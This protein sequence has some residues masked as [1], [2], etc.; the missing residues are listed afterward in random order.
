[1]HDLACSRSHH[2]EHLYTSR[3]SHCKQLNSTNAVLWPLRSELA[4]GI[5]SP[6]TGLKSESS[7]LCTLEWRLH[8]TRGSFAD[9]HQSTPLWGFPV[10]P[11]AGPVTV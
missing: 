6:I 5:R 4:R 10:C 8:A 7:P 3:K 2:I 9:T 1:M 11:K